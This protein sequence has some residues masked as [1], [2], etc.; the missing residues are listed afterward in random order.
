M[1]TQPFPGWVSPGLVE[2]YGLVE[3][4]QQYF[5]VEDERHPI[6]PFAYLSYGNVLNDSNFFDTQDS[7]VSRL[8]LEYRHPL[9]DLRLVEFCL[10]LPPLP[11]CV[12]KEILRA[13]MKGMLPKSVLR[14]PKTPLAGHPYIER[15]QQRDARWVDDY[16]AD[17]RLDRYVIR[18][19]LPTVWAQ[20]DPLQTWVNLRPLSLNIWLKTARKLSQQI[21]KGAGH[22]QI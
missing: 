21:A 17:G 13:A 20:K 11:W 3:R 6:R 14:R 8:P 10:A 12:R 18:S 2:Q 19:R 16:E 15:L 22:A 4:W 9:L 7:G 1:A 5:G